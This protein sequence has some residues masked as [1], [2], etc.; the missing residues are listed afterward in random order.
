MS[1]IQV[2]NTEN[3]ENKILYVLLKCPQKQY[4]IIEN[5]E[6]RFFN[7]FINSKIFEEAKKLFYE[8]KLI[9]EDIIANRLKNPKIAEKLIDILTDF[10]VS[11]LVES[12]CE[13]LFENY[14][15]KL[16]ISAKT[17]EDVKII[18][19][20]R[21][22]YTFNNQN[23]KHISED[24]D[25]LTTGYEK[26]NNEAIYT[27]Y[28]KL[29]DCIG[30]FRGGDYI[31]L[32]GS[33]GMGKT[34]IA[35]NLARQACIQERRVLYFSL[36]MTLP[37]LQNRFVCLNEGLSASKYRSNG[38][39]LTEWQ[40]YKQGLENLKQWTLDTVCDF[41][42]TLEKLHTYLQKG[43]EK[44]LNF[45][46][47]D[48]LGLINGYENK[49]LYEKTT[50]IS[51]RIKQYAGEFDIPILVLVQLNRDLKNRQEKRPQLS[52]IRESGAIEQDSD[53]VLFA[54][55]EGYYNKDVSQNELEIIIAKNR[56]GT[57]NKIIKLNFDLSTQLIT[58]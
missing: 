45:A 48:Y 5:L 37:Q 23:I 32:G 28:G 20:L 3:I 57:N 31:A 6:A 7:N 14:I 27:L 29:D 56:H 4:F 2:C 34:T 50:L 18:N 30:S 33:T 9:D 53:F 24:I 15:S 19:E 42:L 58:E 52:D 13:T 11:P 47:I 44:G 35:L 38:F 12:Y 16:V 25:I 21:E 39:N 55:R 40:R 8:G 26:Q 10:A 36:E 1:T 51:R 46:V 49:S 43:K 22:K 17:Q 41:N 54:H